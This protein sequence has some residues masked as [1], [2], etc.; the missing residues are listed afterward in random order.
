MMM[1]ERQKRP[2]GRT[3]LTS[4]NGLSRAIPSGISGDAIWD[5]D[6]TDTAHGLQ[7]E[8]KLWVLFDLAPEAGDLHVDRALERDA[9]A[10][11]E[12]GA[13]ERPASIGCEELQ[14]GCFRTRQVDG[15]SLAFQLRAFRIE[16]GIAHADL[17]MGRARRRHGAAEQGLDP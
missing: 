15:F 16:H 17:C 1:S 11:A 7:I 6:I 14:K 5:E 9:E 13:R 8:W 3:R 10:G 4:R 2:R 12:I